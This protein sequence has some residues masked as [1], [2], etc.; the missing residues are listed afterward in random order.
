MIQKCCATSLKVRFLHT[1]K[2]SLKIKAVSINIKTRTSFRKNI[3]RV[4]CSIHTHDIVR[5]AFRLEKDG[6]KLS[7]FILFFIFN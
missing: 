3:R 4:N 2:H 7:F 6:V 1:I 5:L